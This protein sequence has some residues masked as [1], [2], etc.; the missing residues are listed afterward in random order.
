MNNETTQ[1]AGLAPVL[2]YL[3]LTF[4]ATFALEGW[5][6]LRGVR[7]DGDVL[8]AGQSL[9]LMAVMWIPGLSALVVT[10]FVEGSPLKAGLS[11]RIGPLAPYLLTVVLTPLAFA[12]MYGLTWALGLSSPDPS[13]TVLAAHTGGEEILT[14]DIVFKL[15][16]PMSIFLGPLINFIFGLG[17]EI[18]WRG[19][20]LPRLMV[21]G[22]VRAHL[23]LGVIWG[24]WHAPLIWAGFNYPGY[25]VAGMAMMC[26]LCLA[27][28]LFINEMTLRYDS[29]LLA[30]FIHAA[31]NAQ[32]FGIWPWLFPGTDPILG[33][34]AGL[35]AVLVWI[36]IGGAAMMLFSRRRKRGETA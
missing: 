18:G 22:K 5:L 13:L 29:A 10:R 15:L 3:A 9:W 6:I 32:G 36:L 34:G 30:G 2:W 19:F 31:V 7:F 21:L 11:L 4:A 23:L 25:P 8:G 20:L 35:T 33:G 17:E 12:A 24:L 1:R 16:L 26:V 28:G 14:P 27:F